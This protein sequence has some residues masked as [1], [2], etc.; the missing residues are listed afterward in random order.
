MKKGYVGS[1]LIGS[2]LV[3]MMNGCSKVG[4][5]GLPEV[6]TNKL[7]SFTETSFEVGGTVVSEGASPILKRG[8][9]WSGTGDPRSASAHKTEDGSGVGTFR[10][11]ITGLEPETRY[12]Y[13][14]YA[15]NSAGTSYGEE[16]SIVTKKATFVPTVTT[17]PVSS[18]ELTTAECGGMVSA[19]GGD[20]VVRCG[21]CWDTNPN[22]TTSSNSKVV[23][24]YSA[25]V[26]SCPLT[27]LNYSTKYYVRAF[28][29]NSK[30]VSYGEEISFTTKILPEIQMTSVVGGTFQMGSSSGLS[31]EKPVHGVTLGN[32]KIGT[33]EIT[34]EIWN[35]VMP[36]SAFRN[37]RNKLPV[38]GVSLNDVMTFITRLSLATNKNYRLPSEAEWEYVA[39]EGSANRTFYATGLNDTLSFAER[40][41]Y[42]ANSE[43]GVHEVG[44]LLPNKLGVYDMGGN[45]MEWCYDWYGEYSSSDVTNPKGPTSGIKKV[46]RGGSFADPAAN[47]RTSM[48][49]YLDPSASNRTTGF[50]IAL[51]E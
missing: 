30:G 36:I 32:F 40:A 27:N 48:R 50:R 14:A 51:T 41:W 47:C 5:E 9:S 12:Y 22:P 45:V 6:T 1:I 18:I 7:I 42:F 20:S 34:I 29:V 43:D 44:T 46:L 37:E 15:T 2:L 17:M 23:L 35:A 25:P 39:G 16:A 31:N 26:F 10:S 33:K 8:I 49:L 28:A 13:R 19:N 24:T 4:E 3:V 11:K 21:I 38:S